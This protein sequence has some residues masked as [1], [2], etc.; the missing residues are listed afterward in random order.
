M[1]VDACYNS[2]IVAK[3]HR[4]LDFLAASLAPDSMRDLFSRNKAE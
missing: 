3:A 4:M 2:T 1:A